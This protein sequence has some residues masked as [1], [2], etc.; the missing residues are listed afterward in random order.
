M[1]GDAKAGGQG[2]RSKDE[3]ASDLRD[4]RQGGYDAVGNQKL[5]NTSQATPHEK[6][7]PGASMQ[8]EPVPAENSEIPEG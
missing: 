7:Q 3:R 1:A 8:G 4:N 5:P 2:P 6:A